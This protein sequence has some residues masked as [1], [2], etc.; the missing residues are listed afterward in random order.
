MCVRNKHCDRFELSLLDHG[1][2]QGGFSAWIYDQASRLVRTAHQVAIRL[3][4]ADGEL[5]GSGGDRRLLDVV[6]GTGRRTA[7]AS[8]R[9]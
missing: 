1:E 9:V 8:E 6:S 2:D 3:V 7:A 5:E 4:G